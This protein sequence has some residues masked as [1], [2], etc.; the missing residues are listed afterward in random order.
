MAFGAFLS[1]YD[2]YLLQNTSNQMI[3]LIGSTQAFLVLALAPI[4]GRLLD[5]HYHYYIGCSGFFLVSIGYI[6]LSFTSGQGLANQGTYWAI[7]L[8]TTIAGLGQACF[9]VYSSQNVAQ[10]FPH[11]KFTVIGITS[12]GAAIGEFLWPLTSSMSHHTFND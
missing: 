9:F 3:S 1:L 4:M 10:W 7:W 11:K 2:V 8:T 6:S 5:A 12:G